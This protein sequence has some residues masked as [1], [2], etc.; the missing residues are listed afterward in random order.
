M[1]IYHKHGA[2]F[3]FAGLL[4]AVLVA[5]SGCYETVIPA[6]PAAETANER[7]AVAYATIQGLADQ[8]RVAYENGLITKES[9]IRIADQL[10]TSYN[11]LDAADVAFRDGNDEIGNGLLTR[12]ATVTENIRLLLVGNDGSVSAP[13][14]GL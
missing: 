3:S 4:L 14:F 8:T 10:R 5:L 1:N 13:L 6:P 12:I 11:L 9:A 2:R 7:L